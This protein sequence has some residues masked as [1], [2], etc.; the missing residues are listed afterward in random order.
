MEYF[1]KLGNR[2][3]IGDFV[4]LNRFYVKYMGTKIGKIINL[5][6]GGIPTTFSSDT[7]YAQISY[8]NNYKLIESFEYVNLMGITK[9]SYEEAVFEM[10]S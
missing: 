10:L 7:P 3:E 6:P 5:Y 8:Q 1:D 4:R 2:L 9:I